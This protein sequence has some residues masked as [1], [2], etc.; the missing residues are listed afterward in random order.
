[1]SND[2]KT[3]HFAIVDQLENDQDTEAEQEILDEHEIQ[4]MELI[5]RIGELIGE[6]SQKKT[7]SD[8]DIATSQPSNLAQAML[9]DRIVDR[10]LDLF[11]N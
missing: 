2:F 6:T 4:L 7:D 3:Y 1:M 10:Q 8:S 11:G 5:D 9:K